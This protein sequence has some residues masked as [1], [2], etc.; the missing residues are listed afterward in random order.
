MNIHMNMNEYS[1]EDEYELDV[2]EFSR[3][4]E[5]SYEHTTHMN[6]NI[7]KISTSKYA[8]RLLFI[9]SL[10]DCLHCSI[11]FIFFYDYLNITLFQW[12]QWRRRQQFFQVLNR[13][14]RFHTQIFV[15]DSQYGW[16]SNS[17]SNSSF[18]YTI[19]FRGASLF[20][21]Q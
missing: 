6:M 2:H 5:Y 7:L 1:Y 11:L 8:E 4:H 21:A 19:K 17:W 16:I 13:I 20:N 12:G 18:V 9:I 3:E 14:V 15:K 10:N